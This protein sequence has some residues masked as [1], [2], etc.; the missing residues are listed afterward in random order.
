[1]KTPASL[2]RSSFSTKVIATLLLISLTIITACGGDTTSP[3]IA[4]NGNAII[5]LNLGDN[6]EELGATAVDNVDGSVDVVIG[7]DTVDVD[8]LGTYTVTYDATD[9][10][11]N[12]ATTVT[13][14]VNVV[15]IPFITTWKTDNDGVSADTEITLIFRDPNFSNTNIEQIEYNHIIDWGDKD[16]AWGDDDSNTLT[17]DNKDGLQAYTHTYE[18]SGTYTVKIIGNFPQIYFPF[19]SDGSSGDSKK[20]LT[21]EQWGDNQW[22]SAYGAFSDTKNLVINATDTPNFSQVTDMFC[23]FC[24]ADAFN[25]D[26]SNWDVSNVVDMSFMFHGTEAFNG[27]L[28]RWNVSNVT[29]MAAMFSFAEAFNGDLSDWNV[30]NVTDMADMFSF[31]EAFNGDLS[32]W[33]VSNV[34]DMAGMFVFAEA[35][36]GDLSDWNVS[37]VTNM[38]SMFDEVTIPT[39]TYDAILINWSALDLQSGVEFSAGNS[40][41]SEAAAGARAIATSKF[42]WIIIDDGNCGATPEADECKPVSE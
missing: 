1:M 20:L 35:F 8:T 32:G 25:G 17:F 38:E 30:S 11:G 3:V 26:L 34:T 39:A 36:N 42:D 10:A 12:E 14:T 9:T 29:D 40:T 18:N 2:L 33:N 6:Y 5:E 13:R 28:S 41:Y 37:S 15:R 27:D 19:D 7:G 16:T 31:A 24:G 22:L 23:M 4:L 21:I